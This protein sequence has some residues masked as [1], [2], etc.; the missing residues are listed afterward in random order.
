LIPSVEKILTQLAGQYS[1]NTVTYYEKIPEQFLE[2]KQYGDLKKLEL[3][4]LLSQPKS[5]EFA[6]QVIPGSHKKQHS[7]KEKTYIVEN[8]NP[9][10]CQLN[11]GVIIMVNSAL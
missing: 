11:A 8:C 3:I 10:D 2:F 6:S 5:K 1:I 7:E 9:V 4:V